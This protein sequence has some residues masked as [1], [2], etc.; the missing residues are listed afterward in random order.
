VSEQP[1]L[2]AIEEI[3]AFVPSAEE[4]HPP[5]RIPSGVLTRKWVVLSLLGQR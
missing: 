3:A 5:A 1:A 4:A 2:C